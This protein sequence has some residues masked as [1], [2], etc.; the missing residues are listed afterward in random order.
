[1]YSLANI[2]YGIN[3]PSGMFVPAIITGAALGRFVGEALQSSGYSVLVGDIHAGVFALIG[4]AAIL[5]GITRMT[6]SIVVII[7]ECTD[8]IT[9]C[10][11]IMLTIM[12]AK[13]VGDS[14]NKGLYDLHL[15]L[16]VW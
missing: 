11:P 4:S 7:I 15:E 8:N 6:I 1:M 16:Q 14:F 12:T 3:V 13:L 5:G 9:Y 10:I 2:T